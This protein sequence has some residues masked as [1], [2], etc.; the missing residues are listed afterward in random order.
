MWQLEGN[1][2]QTEAVRLP[3]LAEWEA[4]ARR[5]HGKEYSWSADEFDPAC[6]NPEESNLGQTTPVHM[7]P[8]GRTKE[9]VW[10]MAGN[11]F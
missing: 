3:A 10:N 4:A 11:V 6:A 9:G 2:Q 7:Y 5:K 1:I 8:A